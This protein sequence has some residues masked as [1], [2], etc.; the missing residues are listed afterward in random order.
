MPTPNQQK[1]KAVGYPRLHPSTVAN[2]SGSALV[3]WLPTRFLIFQGS[4]ALVNPLQP[5]SSSDFS[6][7]TMLALFLS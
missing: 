2:V 1:A 6:S 7:L 4:D 3:I 5:S